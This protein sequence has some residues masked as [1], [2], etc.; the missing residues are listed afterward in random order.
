ME[1]LYLTKWSSSLHSSPLSVI[2]LQ[3][4][5]WKLLNYTLPSCYKVRKSIWI[6][7]SFFFFLFN[8]HH[9]LMLGFHG[10]S[11]SKESRETQVWSLG[12]EDP[13]K[14]GMAT[15]SSILAWRISW[16]EES[17]RLPS[18]GLQR[19]RHNWV[20]FTSHMLIIKTIQLFFSSMCQ[21]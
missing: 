13:L 19:V 9:T 4:S 14:K 12:W 5:I 6:L 2:C 18:M 7:F 11:D 1:T 10:G 20:A 15:H 16:T 21:S 8:A 17:G 3:P